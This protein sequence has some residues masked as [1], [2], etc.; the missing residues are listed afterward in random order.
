LPHKHFRLRTLGGLTLYLP[1]GAEDRELATRRRKLAVLAYL[2]IVDKPVARA[3]LIEL[4]WGDQPE[5]RARHSLSDSLSSLRRVLGSGAVS[6]R[7]ADV[8]LDSAGAGLSI[9]AR[10]L[11]QASVDGRHADVVALYEGPFLPAFAVPGSQTFDEWIEQERLRLSKLFSRSCRA[12][13]L[14]FERQN[15]WASSL[16]LGLRW[17]EADPLSTGAQLAVLKGHASDGNPDALKTA[18]REFRQLE[19]RLSRDFGAL[20]DRDVRELVESWQSRLNDAGEDT[21]VAAVPAASGTIAPSSSS[22]ARVGRRTFAIGAVAVAAVVALVAWST[23]T[24]AAPDEPRWIV[25]ADVENKTGDSVFDRTVSVALAAALTQSPYVR[26]V[27]PD[28][29]SRALF[30]MRRPTNDPTLDETLAREIAQRDG[31]PVVVVPSVHS[32]GGS[33][34]LTTR[35]LDATSGA[36]LSFSAVRASDRAGVL[37]ALD[38]LGRKVRQGLGETSRSIRANSV[39]LPLAT[40]SSLDALKK[41]AEGLRAYRKARADDAGVLWKEAAALDTNFALAY[42]GLAMLGYRDNRSAEGDSLYALAFARFGNLTEREQVLIRSNAKSWRGD[43]AAAAEMLESYLSAHPQD[44]GVLRSLAYDYF[45]A[46]RLNEAASAFQRVLAIDSVDYNSWI[47]LATV[48]DN[49]GNQDASLRA[50][51][52]V[53]RLAPF[54]VTAND[55]INLEY[56]TTYVKAGHLDSAASLI[57]ELA[58]APDDLRRARGLRSQSYLKALAGRYEEASSD[59]ADAIVLNRSS[60]QPNSEIRNRLLLAMM[61]EERNRRRDA[62]VQLDS[63]YALLQRSDIEATMVFWVGKA[64]ARSGDTRRASVLLERI[65][66][67]AR[68]DSPTDRAALGGLRGEIQI[69]RRDTAAVVGLQQAL[70][71]NSSSVLQESVA[72]AAMVAGRFDEAATMYEKLASAAQFGTEGQ[73]LG[74]F[75]LY[76]LA[77]VREREGKPAVARAAYERFLS[78]WPEVDSTLT[79]VID[80]RARLEQLRRGGRGG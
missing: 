43:Y 61:L 14:E 70:E 8:Q 33:Y 26:V 7:L 67:A 59:L 53:R 50:Y 62:T 16:A 27:A 30:R 21:T 41:Y 1:N 60:K 54:L 28:R 56:A 69:A 49:R 44:F 68:A 73:H 57:A 80:A 64:L 52:R 66:R 20:P 32:A 10:E 45:R 15:D 5:D 29:I 63:A 74:R 46:N 18:L 65:E 13:C 23:R 25:V 22:G 3:T 76:W 75:G 6:A 37:D 35:I 42:A 9:D 47:N 11:T 2:A 39:A 19:Q 40:T 79:S 58:A 31:V 77:R 12:L 36:V 34:E 48:E 78:G 24:P 17:L 51:G 4:F 55:N 38:E 71:A 72:H